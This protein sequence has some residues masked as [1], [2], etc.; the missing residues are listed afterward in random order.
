[1]FDNASLKISLY[2]YPTLF[3]VLGTWLCSVDGWFWGGVAL[4]LLALFVAL[5]IG[6]VAV[7][8]ERGEYL[9][10]HTDEINAMTEFYK[11]VENMTPEHKYLLG[12]SFAPEEVMVKVDQTKKV[13]NEFSQLWRKLPVAPYKMKVIAQAALAGERFTFRKWAG[14]GKLLTPAEWTALKD[15]M[16]E[17]ALIEQDNDEAPQQGFNWTGL[18]IDV[19]ETV[20]KDS[21]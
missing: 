6:I 20:V 9:K 5:H 19:M 18:G 8:R 21:I 4:F 2:I 13:G 10:D 1:M 7:I 15:K 12:L 17:M 14:K 16:L 11:R 3:I